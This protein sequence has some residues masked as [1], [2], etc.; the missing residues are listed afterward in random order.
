[1]TRRVLLVAAALVAV[2][3]VALAALTG[4]PRTPDEK[5]VAAADAFL[6]RYVLPH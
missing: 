4:G 2:P 3:A 5:A 6:D 1:M